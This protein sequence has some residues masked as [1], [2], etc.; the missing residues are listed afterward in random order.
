MLRDTIPFFSV[1]T[2]HAL[3]L[4]LWRGGK[5][6]GRGSAGR[7]HGFRWNGTGVRHGKPQ[8]NP[9]GAIR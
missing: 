9:E 1:S 3:R 6:H 8:V 2:R 4:V 7:R 5:R